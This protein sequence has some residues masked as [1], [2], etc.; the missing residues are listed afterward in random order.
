MSGPNVLFRAKYYTKDSKEYGFYS[1]Q[2]SGSDYLNYVDSGSRKK[3]FQDYMAYQG[4]PEK[5]S[6]VFSSEGLLS[7][8]EKARIRKKLKETDS[9]IWDCLLSFSE[10]FGKEHLKTWKD[11]QA[12]LVKQLP[13]LFEENGM[14]Y[15]NITWFAGMHENTDNRH[16]HICFFEKEPLI[17]TERHPEGK[18]HHGTLKKSSMDQLKVDVEMMMLDPEYEIYSERNAIAQNVKEEL[19]HKEDSPIV[20]GPEMQE[21]LLALMKE[22]PLS[23]TG[24]ESHAMD[25]CREDIDAIVTMFLVGNKKNRTEYLEFLEKLAKKDQETIRICQSQHV[26]YEKRLI[27]VKVRKDL[28][29]RLGNQVIDYVQKA[30]IQEIQAGNNFDPGRKKRWDEKKQRSYLLSHALTLEA[31]VDAERNA[32]FDE[33]LKELER[34]QEEREGTTLG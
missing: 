34:V 23:K 8:K 13:K 21:R 27:A 6:G 15:S 20:S 9:Q 12:I 7:S 4:N 5:S 1:S 32:A 31:K 25:G 17:L 3:P 33:F 2:K 22:I 30:K 29:R 18:F 11:A 28:Y 19:S 16:I 10:D 24:Y 14:D 26:P